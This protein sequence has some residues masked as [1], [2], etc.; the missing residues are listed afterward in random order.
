LAVRADLLLV[1]EQVG[2]RPLKLGAGGLIVV[3]AAVGKLGATRVLPMTFTA[4]DTVIAG[5]TTSFPV[6]VAVLT[7]I[8]T[9]IACALGISGVARL[10]PNYA[11][12]VGLGE[13]LC[14]V[15]GPRR[16]FEKC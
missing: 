7:V 11:S 1:V 5:H 6:P 14:A 3:A 16:N 15:V 8:S 4:N 2:L 10:R 13:V 12:L 9:A